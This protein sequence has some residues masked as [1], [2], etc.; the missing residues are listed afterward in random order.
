MSLAI[1]LRRAL[2][3]RERDRQFNAAAPQPA[4]VEH[5]AAWNLR[6]ASFDFMV[7]HC[8]SCSERVGGGQISP[9]GR[10]VLTQSIGLARLLPSACSCRALRSWASSKARSSTANPRVMVTMCSAAIAGAPSN[11]LRSAPLRKASS[12]KPIMRASRSA[13][14]CRAPSSDPCRRPII[15][16]REIRYGCDRDLFRK[17]CGRRQRR[18]A[19]PFR[20][21]AWRPWTRCALA[22]DHVRPKAGIS[23]DRRL[24]R[25]SS[26]LGPNACCASRVEQMLRPPLS[27][28]AIPSAR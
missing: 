20:S 27:L 14:A 17:S 2:G 1:F 10:R 13:K 25:K 16:S 3:L 6:H 26:P 21:V 22:A 12:T 7:L 28:A 23:H 24:L 9:W 19:G 5:A 8:G 11:S 15:R 18:S 4:T